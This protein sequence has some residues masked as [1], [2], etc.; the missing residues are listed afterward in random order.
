MSTLVLVHAKSLEEKFIR[1]GFGT[2]R[3]PL[4]Y[5][6]FVIVGPAND[7]AGIK[8]LKAATEALRKISERRRRLH[9]P[10]RQI[11]HP[12]G[13]NGTLGEGRDQAVRRLV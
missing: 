13:G 4:M 10:W 9:K 7:P 3:I 12:C 6:D 2:E 1:D 11:G 5:N 8:G